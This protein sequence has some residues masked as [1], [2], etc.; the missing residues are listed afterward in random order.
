MLHPKIK[1][2]K[3]KSNFRVENTIGSNGFL[4]VFIEFVYPS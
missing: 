4:R 2:K 3:G 1:R